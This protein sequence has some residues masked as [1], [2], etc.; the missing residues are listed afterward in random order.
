MGKKS[1]RDRAAY[2]SQMGPRR[3]PTPGRPPVLDSDDEARLEKIRQMSLA[4]AQTEL[5]TAL[6]AMS[7]SR[8]AG[9]INDWVK[10]NRVQEALLCLTSLIAYESDEPLY[11]K[12]YTECKLPFCAEPE[13]L[14]K[15]V[16]RFRRYRKYWPRLR[17]RACWGCGKQYDL[18]EP[19]LWV[20]G[21]CGDAR[22]C[23]EAC[24]AADWPDHRG[25]C[26]AKIR[27]EL[28]K[29]LSEGKTQDEICHELVHATSSSHK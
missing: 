1:R 2:G 8:R 22:Y 10:D 24:Q 12:Q 25:Y 23:N 7:K 5:E 4:E 26:I 29:G 28:H 19:R 6:A 9:T 14:V 11:L 18:S 15:V 13:D 20:C 3:G 17:R 27:R 16:M 21:G